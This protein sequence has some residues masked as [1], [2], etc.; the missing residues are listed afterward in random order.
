MSD[1]DRPVVLDCPFCG[2]PARVLAGPGLQ[3]VS[4]TVC[5][6]SM[7]ATNVLAMWNRRVVTSGKPEAPGT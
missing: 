6:A 4:C 2:A 1:A 7:T 3:F 5:P